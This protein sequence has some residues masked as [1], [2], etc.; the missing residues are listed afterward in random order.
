MDRAKVAPGG[1]AGAGMST[2]ASS[3]WLGAALAACLLLAAPAAGQTAPAPE[4]AER[5]A[6][7]RLLKQRVL[8]EGG[9][10]AQNAAFDLF[11]TGR[12]GLGDLGPEGSHD[13]FLRG[14]F[15]GDTPAGARQAVLEAL[16]SCG[17]FRLQVAFDLIR[18]GFADPTPTITQLALGVLPSLDDITEDRDPARPLAPAAD[19]YGLLRQRLLELRSARPGGALGREALALIDGLE[20]MPNPI[21]SV[22]VLISVLPSKGG[23]QLLS[24]N[25][26]ER[27]REALQRMTV[28]SFETGDE[29]RAWYDAEPSRRSL[30]DWRL[31][32][33][34]RRDNRVKLLERDATDYFLRFIGGLKPEE[35]LIELK[36]SADKESTV[37]RA[38]IRELGLLA[39]Q[40]SQD[41]GKWL[42]ERLKGPTQFHDETKALCIEALGESGLV[43]AAEDIVP[44]LNTP[45]YSTRMRAAAAQA[46]G[47]LQAA[48]AMD[49]LLEVM[50]RPDLSDDL[51]RAI[52]EAL[53]RIGQNPD[54]RV[55]RR[56]VGFAE[57]LQGA[58]NGAAAPAAELL[59]IT[60]RALG[61]L[62][63]PEATA[64]AP[65]QPPTPHPDTEKAVS[66][67]AGLASH[68]DADVRLF[69]VTAL[70]TMPP[71][72]PFPALRDRLQAEAAV[73]VRRAIVDAIGQHAVDNWYFA[74]GEYLKAAV[75]LLV[76]L[77]TTNADEIM[78]ARAQRRLE[79]IA[80]RPKDFLTNFV[81]LKLV[82]SK[83]L[84]N[85]KP[86]LAVPFLKGDRLPPAD[87]VGADHRGVYFQLLGV[88]AEGQLESDPAAAL[89]DYEAVI[90]GLSL[91]QP[92]SVTARALHLGRARAMLR[93]VPPRAREALPQLLAVLQSLPATEPAPEVW[94]AVVD[95]AEK[96]AVADRAAVGPA[97]APFKPL[98]GSAPLAVQGRLNELD[99]RGAGGGK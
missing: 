36:K 81:G 89:A 50:A 28:K 39:R 65:G 80:T 33:Y 62:R 15:R 82:V 68:A 79:E 29:W 21:R 53:G 99:G 22:D 94:A 12:P 70:G 76:P 69:A 23:V 58:V 91:Q 90:Q 38:A 95:A 60:A 43:A 57:G 32:I 48:G 84:E 47:G 88:R 24:R 25:L 11:M 74:E 93:L 92:G 63:Y 45:D 78:R 52:I 5:D 8:Q 98:L 9:T 20:R 40:G 30:Y 19:I 4:A 31:E 37:R 44:F 72:R 67:V 77:L 34:R 85:G 10:I 14:V 18:E 17:R 26:E 55:S 73:H 2:C 41:A 51:R 46:L 86:D 3:T 61:T 16:R 35:R 7:I 27:I 6:R 75:D 42:R 96:L 83:I 87:Q 71:P 97:L 54:A 64:G 13:D 59:A 1:G 66:L 49:T 56:L